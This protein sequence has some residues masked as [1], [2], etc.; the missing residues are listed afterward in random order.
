MSQSWKWRVINRVG[1][2]QLST[3]KIKDN[4]NCKPCVQ[5]CLRKGLNKILWAL[6][7]SIFYKHVKRSNILDMRGAFSLAWRHWGSGSQ[8]V[9]QGHLTNERQN[10]RSQFHS[11]SSSSI[12]FTNS[13]RLNL[14]N[15][16]RTSLVVQWVRSGLPL[17]G[18]RFP[19]LVWGDSKRHRAT[20]PKRCSSWSPCAWE[21]MLHNRGSHGEEEPGHRNQ[22]KPMGNS[23]DPVQPKI[24]KLVK[25]HLNPDHSWS[26]YFCFHS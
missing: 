12:P 11:C 13:Q 21:P 4:Y 8:A 10:W 7:T 17:Q 5:P 23:E 2:T 25:I 26:H 20:N 19:H 15:T 16:P 22:E 18:T 6:Y 9:G 3:I 1:V 14:R 24:N